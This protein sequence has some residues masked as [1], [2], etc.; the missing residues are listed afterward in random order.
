MIKKKDNKKSQL[1]FHFISE[2]FQNYNPTYGLVHKTEIYFSFYKSVKL[3]RRTER[4]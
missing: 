3:L 4:N 1:N 2:Q